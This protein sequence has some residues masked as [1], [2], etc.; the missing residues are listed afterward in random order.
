MSSFTQRLLL[1]LDCP[2]CFTHRYSVQPKSSLVKELFKAVQ[3]SHITKV[4]EVKLRLFDHAEK[5]VSAT[6]RICS[7][8]IY[9]A[10]SRPS[11]TQIEQQ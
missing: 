6:R 4:Q 11:L 3:E 5:E 9:W 1:F 2:V 7:V 8:H 10:N